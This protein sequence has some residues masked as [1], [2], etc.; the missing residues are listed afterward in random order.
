M[1]AVAAELEVLLSD[2]DG[3]GAMML[4]PPLLP[5]SE[6]PSLLP[7]A[8]KIQSGGATTVGQWT[9]H[10][11]KVKQYWHRV[12]QGLFSALAGI[13]AGPKRGAAGIHDPIC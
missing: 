13:V 6:I 10:R 9:G 11:I 7:V 2:V 3:Q 1:A 12:L 4:P 8:Q 5:A